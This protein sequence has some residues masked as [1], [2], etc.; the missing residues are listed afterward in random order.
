MAVDSLLKMEHKAW[1]TLS[2]VKILGNLLARYRSP[3]VKEVSVFCLAVFSC[4]RDPQIKAFWKNET[5]IS[6]SKIRNF[7]KKQDSQLSRIL[8][9]L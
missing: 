8:R 6:F 9:Y 5:K 3:L 1:D 4:L 2:R 7:K